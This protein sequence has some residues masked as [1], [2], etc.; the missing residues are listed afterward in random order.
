LLATRFINIITSL[1]HDRSRP[2]MEPLMSDAPLSPEHLDAVIDAMRQHLGGI[3]IGGSRCH[4]VFAH[5]AE[6]GWF[7]EDFDEGH[8][9]RHAMTEAQVREGIRDQGQTGRALLY[10]IARKPGVEAM[11]RD[12]T[13]AVLAAIEA[14]CAFQPI[15]ENDALLRAVLL[16]AGPD[17]DASHLDALRSQIEGFTLWHVFMNATGWTRTPENGQRALRFLDRVLALIGP[18]RPIYTDRLLASFAELAG[19]VPTTIAAL[20][21]SILIPPRYEHEHDSA[22]KR[23]A[24]LLA[25]QG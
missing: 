25:Q 22:Q 6:T 7:R 15:T 5:S 1:D 18:P 11:L 10:S 16:G 19:D 3:M 23:L 2:A 24:A 21:R 4:T 20:Q 9:E 17:C 8:E 14:A 12:D 13:P